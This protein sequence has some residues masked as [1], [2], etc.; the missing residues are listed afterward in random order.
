VGK[1]KRGGVPV[2]AKKRRNCY[3]TALRTEKKKK[4]SRAEKGKK[5]QEREEKKL[6]PRGGPRDKRG[7]MSGLG[8]RKRT[9]CP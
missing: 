1:A 2:T 8:L 3:C 9:N 6:G 7:G 4:K 5:R